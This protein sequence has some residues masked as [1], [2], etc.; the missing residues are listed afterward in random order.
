MNWIELNEGIQTYYKTVQLI[1]KYGIEQTGTSQKYRSRLS[2]TE[3]D[4]FQ[5]L[6]ITYVRNARCHCNI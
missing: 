1:E 3:C 6:F 5:V 2:A 4:R